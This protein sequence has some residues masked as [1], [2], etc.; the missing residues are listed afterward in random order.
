M[1]AK[2]HCPICNDEWQF[3]SHQAILTKE[4]R[5]DLQTHGD[6]NIVCEDCCHKE[7]DIERVAEELEEQGR[8]LSFVE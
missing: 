5:R 1:M 7:E 8:V 4:E 3:N 2:A 6:L